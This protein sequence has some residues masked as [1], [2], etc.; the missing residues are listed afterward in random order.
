MRETY[1]NQNKRKGNK[2][3]TKI[4]VYLLFI[5]LFVYAGSA[6]AFT[7]STASDNN[8]DYFGFEAGRRSGG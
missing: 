2:M 1:L 6:S 5:A 4:I 3:K 8:S 7:E